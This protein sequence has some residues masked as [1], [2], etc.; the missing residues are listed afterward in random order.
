[1]NRRAAVIEHP[2]NAELKLVVSA[3]EKGLRLWGTHIE[4]VDAPKTGALPQISNAVLDEKTG[5]IHVFKGLFEEEKKKLET[6]YRDYLEEK[7]RKA[8][9]V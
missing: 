4:T 7:T 2:E 6:R 9:A 3:D 8:L 1:M 5:K